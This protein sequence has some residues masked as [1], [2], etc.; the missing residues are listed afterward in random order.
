[1]IIF[2]FRLTQ[3]K[4]LYLFFIIHESRKKN[5]KKTI[6]KRNIFIRKKRINSKQVRLR[7]IVAKQFQILIKIYGRE[8]GLKEKKRKQNYHEETKQTDKVSCREDVQ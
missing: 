3:R 4:R 7:S 8:R 2:I 6:K 5:E 1:M